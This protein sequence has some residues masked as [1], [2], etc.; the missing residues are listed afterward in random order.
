MTNIKEQYKIL[1]DVG[2]GVETDKKKFA[3]AFEKNAVL[4]PTPKTKKNKEK[5]K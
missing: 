3:P 2:K 4:L 1:K 5:T